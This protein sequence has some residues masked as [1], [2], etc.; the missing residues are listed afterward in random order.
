M[1][2]NCKVI[3]IVIL[4]LF[5]RLCIMQYVICWHKLELYFVAET[6]KLNSQPVRTIPKG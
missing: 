1:G 3:V 5:W 4:L 6:Y 2:V